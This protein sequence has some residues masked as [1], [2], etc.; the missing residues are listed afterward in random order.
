MFICHLTVANKVCFRVGKRREL[1]LIWME[2]E[3]RRCD[4]YGLTAGIETLPPIAALWK[5]LLSE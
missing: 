5:N 4:W 1:A 3:W 2:S